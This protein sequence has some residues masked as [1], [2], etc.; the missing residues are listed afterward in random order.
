MYVASLL[1]RFMH[2]PTNKHYGTTKRVLRYV[3]GILHYGLE[4]VKGKNA[5]LIGFCDSD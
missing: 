5:M 3:K 2:C 1:A 4:H